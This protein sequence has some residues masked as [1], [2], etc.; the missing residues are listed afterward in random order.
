MSELQLGNDVA[1]EIIEDLGEDAYVVSI[2]GKL[3]RT[4]CRLNKKPQ[5]GETIF[6]RVTAVKPL[7]FQQI[8]YST[9]SLDLKA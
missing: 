8:H 6:C 4:R 7:A 5:I 2:N 3:L 9:L 1:V